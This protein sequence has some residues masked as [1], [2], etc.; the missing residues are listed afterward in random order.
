MASY[1]C[2]RRSIFFNVALFFLIVI[3]W[4]LSYMQPVLR[5]FF[6]EEHVFYGKVSYAS[7]P[8][9]FGNTDIPFLDKT[10]FQ[11]NGDTEATFVLYASQEMLDDMSDWFSFAARDAENV[12]L[13]IYAVRIN[14]SKFIVKSLAT[15]NYILP[16]DTVSEYQLYYS[17]LGL[18]IDAICFICMVVFLVLG[19]KS[20]R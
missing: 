2:T 17:L 7:I 15:T 16:W 4:T 20:K 8:S 1:F 10:F 5:S 18:G 9:L 13:E 12:P 19:I 11:I 3:V 6:K 14:E